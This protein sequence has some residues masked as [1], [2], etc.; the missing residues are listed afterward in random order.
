MAQQENFA[1][2]NDADEVN[3]DDINHFVTEWEKVDVL[4]AKVRT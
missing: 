4:A 1:E 3:L 2:S